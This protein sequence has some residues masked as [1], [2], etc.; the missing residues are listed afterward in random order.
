MYG[1][2]DSETVTDEGLQELL[3]NNKKSGYLD[4]RK[5]KKPDFVRPLRATCLEVSHGKK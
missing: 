4:I 5:Y 2:I 3:H 1:R